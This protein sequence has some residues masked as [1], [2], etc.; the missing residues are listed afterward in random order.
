MRAGGWWVRARYLAIT[1]GALAATLVAGG[2]GWP[3][4]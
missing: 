4:H 2:A 3:K 1:L